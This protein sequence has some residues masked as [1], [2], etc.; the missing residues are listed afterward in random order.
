MFGKGE[1]Y[2]CFVVLVCKFIGGCFYVVEVGGVGNC[3]FV[4]VGEFG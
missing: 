1:C 2:F 4:F 3:F